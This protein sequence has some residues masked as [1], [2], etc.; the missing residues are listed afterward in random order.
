MNPLPTIKRTQ[1]KISWNINTLVV[2]H[3][4]RYGRK[5]V[6][7]DKSMID[8]QNN[9]GVYLVFGEYIAAKKQNKTKQIRKWLS[10]QV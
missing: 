5:Y 9:Q 2:F 6:L 8:F 10:F 3:F 4:R 7:F 1:I